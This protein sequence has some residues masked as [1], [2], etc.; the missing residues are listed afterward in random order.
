MKSTKTPTNFPYSGTIIL[1][2]SILI[3]S[4]SCVKQTA[5]PNSNPT[6]PNPPSS[7]TGSNIIYTDVNPDSATLLS[8][9]SFNLNLNNDGVTDFEFNK[10]LSSSECR[11]P[12]QPTF[13]FHIHLSVT[14]AKAGNAIMTNSSNL[15][16]L[17]L[18]SSTP[19]GPDSLWATTS[20]VLLE[21]GAISNC[22]SVMGHAGYWINISDK[23]IGLKF[24]KDNNT[25]YGWARLTSTYSAISA[26][27]LI[28]GGDLII[29]DY[30]YNNVPNQPIV[31]GQNK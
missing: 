19:I 2:I 11:S 13:T 6:K 23:Y 21:G 20:E 29:K 26:S 3:F 8:T 17:A 15:L 18:D 1:F 28:I 9:D 27:S 25:Y 14:P 30:A 24:I 22:T 5:A 10:S 4:S 31:A 7:P 12:E 16:A